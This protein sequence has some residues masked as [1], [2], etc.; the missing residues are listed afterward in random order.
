MTA[1]DYL[2]LGDWKEERTIVSFPGRDS[3]TPVSVL[4]RTLEKARAGHIKQ[5]AVVIVLDDDE[6]STSCDYSA[7]K[8]SMLLYG[9]ESLRIG[10]NDQMRDAWEPTED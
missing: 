10:I 9:C 5:V 3:E 7:G 4:A 8:L 1:R 2:T 6:E